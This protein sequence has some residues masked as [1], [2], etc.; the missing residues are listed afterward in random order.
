MAKSDPNTGMP[1]GDVTGRHDS[2]G[3]DQRDYSHTDNRS[4]TSKTVHNGPGTA[5][6]T[7][8]SKP[9]APVNP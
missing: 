3:V 1:E 6:S 7:P 8:Q 2:D 4:G 5:G 9:G